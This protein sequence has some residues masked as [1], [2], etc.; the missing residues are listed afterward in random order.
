MI[1]VLMFFAYCAGYWTANY[2]ILNFRLKGL[3]TFMLKRL[4]RAMT[5]ILEQRGEAK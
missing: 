2:Y 5:L 4:I 3:K 1:Y